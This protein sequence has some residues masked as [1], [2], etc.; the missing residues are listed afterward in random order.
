MAALALVA[1]VNE[2]EAVAKMAF[3]RMDRR[4]VVLD[5]DVSLT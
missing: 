3:W 1:E 5:E 4:V 2:R